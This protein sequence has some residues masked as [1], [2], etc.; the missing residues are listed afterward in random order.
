MPDISTGTS[1]DSG[2]P[3]ANP[4][5]A[6]SATHAAQPIMCSDQKARALFSKKG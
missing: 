1:D 6:R 4:D 5:V 2:M 3:L